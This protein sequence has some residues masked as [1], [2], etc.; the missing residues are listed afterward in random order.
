METELKD[1]VCRV[2]CKLSAMED[3]FSLYSIANDKT[4]LRGHSISGLSF[5]ISDC[6]EELRKVIDEPLLE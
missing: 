5:I 1:R 2:I 4:A 3:L 6:T